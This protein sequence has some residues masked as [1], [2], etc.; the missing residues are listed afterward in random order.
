MCDRV[1]MYP[2]PVPPAVPAWR[3]YLIILARMAC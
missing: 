3:L 1:R 2:P